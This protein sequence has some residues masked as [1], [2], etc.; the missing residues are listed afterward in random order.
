MPDCLS[1]RPSAGSISASVSGGLW[2]WCS[3]GWGHTVHQY[4]VDCG[5]GE[6]RGGAYGASVSG[7][8]WVW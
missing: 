1:L 4:Q 5:S 8:L 6:V 2:V 3:E 7:G